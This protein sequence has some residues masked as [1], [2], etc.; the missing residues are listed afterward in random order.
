MSTLISEATKLSTECAGSMKRA[1][2]SMPI[3]QKEGDNIEVMRKYG[4]IDFVLNQEVVSNF[5]QQCCGVMSSHI[6]KLLVESK[7]QIMNKRRT[8]VTIQ[9]CI[10][11]K[12]LW[13][14]VCT[15]PFGSEFSVCCF[16][17]NKNIRIYG[18]VIL[19]FYVDVKLSL[20][21]ERKDLD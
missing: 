17:L 16:L 11:E 20:S 14:R 8:A 13:F 15:L 1:F 19:P 18:A 3:S 21:L 10:K 2:K 6:F 4:F 7:G 5:L 9:K 12:I